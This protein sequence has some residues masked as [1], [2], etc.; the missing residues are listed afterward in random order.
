MVSMQE[1]A[2]ESPGFLVLWRCGWNSP[3]CCKKS[4]LGGCLH[5]SD[6]CTREACF[7]EWTLI[8]NDL[9]RLIAMSTG[10]MILVVA[11]LTMVSS[12]LLVLPQALDL[13]LQPVNLLVFGREKLFDYFFGNIVVADSF[14]DF[15]YLYSFSFF[16]SSNFSLSRSSNFSN[17]SIVFSM[18]K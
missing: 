14:E 17:N 15:K 6:H 5:I 12:N 16:K 4:Y 7:S 3:E 2:E 9:Q 10:K 13:V 11:F 1:Y 8:I 18:G